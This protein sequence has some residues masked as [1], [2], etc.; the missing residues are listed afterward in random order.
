MKEKAKIVFGLIEEIA[1][2]SNLKAISVN[3]AS[4]CL[5]IDRLTKDEFWKGGLLT[6][7]GTRLFIEIDMLKNND[8]GARFFVV[9]IAI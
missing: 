8:F 4:I 6:Y 1:D 7:F 9:D 5:L 2:I 3:L